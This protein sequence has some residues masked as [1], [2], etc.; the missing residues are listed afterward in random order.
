MPPVS[1]PISPIPPS[2]LV[3]SLGSN[4][5]RGSLPTVLSSL[6]GLTVLNVSGNY[7][8]G[9]ILDRTNMPASAR[10][11][12]TNNY[13]TGDLQQADCV[14]ANLKLAANCF[15]TAAAAAAL[16]VTCTAQRLPAVCAALCGMNGT[17]TPVCNG[18][19]L[20]YL[21]GLSLAPTC[22]CLNG[23]VQ[24]RRSSCAPPGMC[25]RRRWSK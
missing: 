14:S 15:S 17:T 12:Y 10:Y 19:G 7:L 18:M 4:Q 11:E 13:F 6:T 21:D 8:T 2:T 22:L 5:L 3:M 24:D 25:S 1:P 23:A 9:P 16:A 20:C